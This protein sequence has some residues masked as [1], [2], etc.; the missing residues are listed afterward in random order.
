M[1]VAAIVGSIRQH[2][3]NLMLAR[4]IVQQLPPSFR[5]RS[6]EFMDSVVYK[7]VNWLKQKK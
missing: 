7:F 5:P 6:M 1:K 2:S 4:F 3:Y